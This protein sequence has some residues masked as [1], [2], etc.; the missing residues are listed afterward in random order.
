VCGSAQSES[1][2]RG[3]NR[4]KKSAVFLRKS[5]LF[6]SNEQSSNNPCAGKIR[7]ALRLHLTFCR[8]EA[9]FG[10]CST[11]EN[12][13][14]ARKILYATDFSTMSDT[15]LE[16]ATSLAREQGGT[17]LIVHVEEPPA[18]YGGVAFDYRP[19]DPREEVLQM[20][21]EVVPTD[22]SVPFEHRLIVGLPAPAILDL[23]R[24]ENVDLIV[25]ATHGR[26]GLARVVMGSVAE[27]VVRKAKCPVLTIKPA[28]AAVAAN[29]STAACAAPA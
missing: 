19:E 16:L 21:K 9:E 13:M 5:A 1:I 14:N 10:V 17:L 27:E 11:K 23:A 26:T 20:L 25:L 29:R 15:A 24:R 3:K 22:I 18:A 28:V 6:A 12:K 8:V 4:P 7:A 2:K